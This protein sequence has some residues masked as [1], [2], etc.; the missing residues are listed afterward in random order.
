[1]KTTSKTM[2]ISVITAA[3]ALALFGGAFVST[4]SA[5]STATPTPTV[6]P[7][8]T[9]NP[10]DVQ[11]NDES[12]AQALIGDNQDELDILNA[13]VNADVSDEDAQAET[14]EAPEI[15][16]EVEAIDAENQQES[17]SFN[18]DI[19]QA[20]QSG[21]HDDAV[22]LAAAAS[23]V[24]SVTAPEAAAMASDDNEAHAILVGTVQK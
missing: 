14:P 3:S 22:E 21:N 18:E 5:D 15:D 20:E 11:V 4:A 13:Q 12:D 10:F 8:P 16:T 24:T 7:A 1:M 9:A 17:D 6:S 19:T 2:K 23:I